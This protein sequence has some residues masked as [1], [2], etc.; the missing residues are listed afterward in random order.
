MRGEGRGERGGELPAG[1]YRLEENRWPAALA[2]EAAANGRRF[3]YLY[4]A[5]I[6]DKR[7]FLAACQAALAFPA[8]FGYNWDAFEELI[9]DLAWA[10]AAGYVLL[11]DRVANF[12][13][14]RP[15][16]WAIALD[17]LRGAAA[18]WARRGVPFTVLLRQDGGAAGGV[19]RLSR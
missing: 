8:Y 3:R 7:T 13:V 1:V 11:Y 4:G 19:P 2:A 14:N 16:E 18:E 5:T 15:A 17:I 9:N 10:P 6:F 12:A